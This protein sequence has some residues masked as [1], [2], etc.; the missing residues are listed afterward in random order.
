MSLLLAIAI[1]FLIRDYLIK[2]G[3]YVDRTESEE[4]APKGILVSPPDGAPPPSTPP[5][6]N[7]N[8]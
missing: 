4:P 2:Q 8:K 7:R 5:K 6:K 3:E 1:W